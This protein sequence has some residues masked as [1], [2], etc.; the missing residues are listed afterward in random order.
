MDVKTLSEAV[1]PILM[2]QIIIINA[3]SLGEGS[4][5]NRMYLLFQGFASLWEQG[6]IKDR[7]LT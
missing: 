4:V 1:K 6:N 3:I 5:N 7:G 2:E